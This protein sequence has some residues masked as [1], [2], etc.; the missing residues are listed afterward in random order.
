MKKVMSVAYSRTPFGLASAAAEEALLRFPS[1]NC[2]VAGLDD[3]AGR[4]AS[5]S[6]VSA[7]KRRA[8]RVGCAYR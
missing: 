5:S 1:G 3:R 2:S 4:N 6:L 7:A 8:G